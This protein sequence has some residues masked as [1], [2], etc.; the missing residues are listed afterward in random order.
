[1]P[2]F[3]YQYMLNHTP[4]MFYQYGCMC[5]FLQSKEWLEIAKFTEFY[6]YR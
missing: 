4:V 1:M 2:S 5:A 6:I 3:H